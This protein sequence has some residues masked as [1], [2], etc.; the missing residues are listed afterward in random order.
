MDQ[1]RGDFKELCRAAAHE[2]DPDKLMVLV[3]EIIEAFD[4]RERK[5]NSPTEREKD[6]EPPNGAYR[7]S[8]GPEPVGSTF[9]RYLS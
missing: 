1:D 4:E 7:P 6:S 9:Y 2:M 5:R 3:A 8:H